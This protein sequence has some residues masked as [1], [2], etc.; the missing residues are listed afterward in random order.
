M[1]LKGSCAIQYKNV[2]RADSVFIKGISSK[3]ILAIK[4]NLLKNSRQIC[5][6]IKISAFLGGVWQCLRKLK[7]KLID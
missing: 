1:F 4:N 3:N 5:K 7:S 6:I 2:I